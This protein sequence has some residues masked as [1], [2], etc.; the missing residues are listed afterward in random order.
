MDDL[1]DTTTETYTLKAHEKARSYLV[2]EAKKLP[3]LHFGLLN[4]QLPPSV[5]SKNSADVEDYL[6]WIGASTLPTANDIHGAIN[7]WCTFVELRASRASDIVNAFNRKYY[8]EHLSPLVDQFAAA[9][10]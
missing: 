9:T 5:A 8:T 6:R 10:R 7:Q 2:E 3:S 1:V 4:R